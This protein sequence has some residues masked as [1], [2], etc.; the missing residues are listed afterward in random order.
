MI[1]CCCSNNESGFELSLSPCGNFISFS[2]MSLSNNTM[3][4]I[5]TC[6]FQASKRMKSR[7]VQIVDEIGLKEVVEE[8]V[9][10]E[11]VAVVVEVVAVVVVVVVER[12]ESPD[13]KK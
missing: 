12:L 1:S 5:W 11:V 10:E 4:S 6:F 3:S 8:E 13:E 7:A 9:S 2:Y